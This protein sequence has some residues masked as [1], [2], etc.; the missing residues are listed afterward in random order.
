MAKEKNDKKVIL[1]ILG[2]AVLTVGGYLL[3]RNYKK[4][5]GTTT[6]DN[7]VLKDVY[8]NLVF[9]TGTA[10]IKP[11][12]FPALDELASVLNQSP[13]WKLSITGHTD[14]TGTPQTNLTLSKKRADSV[15]S[16]LVSKGVDQLR[17]STQGMG[18]TQPIADNATAEGREMNRRVEFL[19][20][21]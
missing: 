20:T 2:L 8:D 17:I 10:T 6:Q 21:K 15:K 1:I 4:K 12:S 5:N 18:Q 19:I 3:Y 13:T 16:Y 11:E 7:P 14:S 9:L